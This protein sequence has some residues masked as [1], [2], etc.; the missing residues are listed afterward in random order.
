MK[1]LSFILV[2]LC[3]VLFG[4]PHNAEIST[5]VK[6]PEYDTISS[7]AYIGGSVVYNPTNPYA[8][9]LTPGVMIAVH[10][11]ELT[12]TGEG[13]N[14]SI[15]INKNT[16]RY[17]YIKINAISSQT[18]IFQYHFFNTNGTKQTQLYTLRKG[19]TLDLNKDGKYDITYTPL[20]PVRTGFEGAMSLEF[21]SDEEA[22]YTT[23]YATITEDTLSRNAGVPTEYENSTFYGVNSEGSFI[24][25]TGE[26]DASINSRSAVSTS[27]MMGISHGDYLINSSTG[28]ILAI[29]GEVPT[30]DDQ[31][32]DFNSQKELIYKSL[33]DYTTKTNEEHTTNQNNLVLDSNTLVVDD[34]LE[35]EQFFT[36]LYRE[37]QFADVINGPKALLRAL[38][39][40]LKEGINVDTCTTEQAIA[41]L[42]RILTGGSIVEILIEANHDVLTP[43]D[44]ADI[45]RVLFDYIDAIFSDEVFERIKAAK[46]NP[47][48][49]QKIINENWNNL[50]VDESKV[51]SAYLELIAMNRLCIERYYPESPRAVVAA[52]DISSVYPMMSLNIAEVSDEYKIS[53]G[54]NISDGNIISGSRN[55][56]VTSSASQYDFT[57]LS[58]PENQLTQGYKNYLAKKDRIDKEFDNYYSLDLSSIKITDI[59]DEKTQK[60]E[61]KDKTEDQ[62]KKPEKGDKKDKPKDREITTDSLH[63][64]L[65]VGITGS[66]E[67][68]KGYMESGLASAIYVSFDG[69]F[70]EFKQTLTPITKEL[71][72]KDRTFMIGPVPITIGF[73]GKFYLGLE[74]D[75]STNVNYAIEF[76]GMYGAGADLSLDYGLK[77]KWNLFSFYVDGSFYKYLINHT[78]YYAGPVTEE[79]SSGSNGGSVIIQPGIELEPSIALGPEYV[80]VGVGVPL[81]IN[82]NIGLGLNFKDPGTKPFDPPKKWFQIANSN[83][84]GRAGIGANIQVQPKIGVKIP[85]IGKRIEV[86]WSAA[87]LAE[88][89]IYLDENYTLQFEGSF[90][91]RN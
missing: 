82:F 33:D 91:G 46:D 84:Y 57:R 71:F 30:S 81:N 19:K 59:E 69:N 42:F 34:S 58:I 79:A 13:E 28:E 88:G 36:Y 90:L 37:N 4:C 23:M 26:N 21:I 44:K 9:Q 56:S 48:E 50:Q 78:E 75:F 10:H 73:E 43:E 52:P 65:K 16:N 22:G 87:T 1:K 55:S 8:A 74:A 63:F 45:E 60:T 14:R 27:T 40:E 6:S 47:E 67:S 85:G 68:R 51:K 39:E 72:D 89:E 7:L 38:P 70:K 86:N 20:V 24:Y 66:F 61:T 62:K 76:V 64:E 18:V 29:V 3:I 54:E 25:I 5:E 49:M 31:D 32:E 35:L 12:V 17:G 80:Y 15:I 41:Q 2:G 83:L 11:G 53:E 77:N